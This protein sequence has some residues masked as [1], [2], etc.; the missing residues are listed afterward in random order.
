MARPGSGDDKGRSPP[1][2][3]VLAAATAT[4]FQS[5]GRNCWDRGPDQH[6]VRDDLRMELKWKGPG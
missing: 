1:T 2:A 4:S 6:S 3:D 5:S